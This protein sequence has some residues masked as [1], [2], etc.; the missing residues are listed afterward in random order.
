MA[1]SDVNSEL[2]LSRLHPL[3]VRIMH[4]INALAVIIMI[5]SGWKIYNDEVIFGW[6][7]FPE[8]NHA[9]RL[10]P[11]RLAMAFLRHVDIR[12]QWSLLCRLWNFVRT[13]S[14]EAFSD[15]GA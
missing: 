9:R 13:I 5:T 6:L 14:K 7:H 1:P 8:A 11:A 10:G 12:A 4:W 15:L 3:P 2:K